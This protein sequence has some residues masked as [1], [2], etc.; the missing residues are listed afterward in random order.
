MEPLVPIGELEMFAHG[1]DHAEGI[2]V[3][4]EGVVYV[5]GEAG[6]LYRIG[7]DDTVE[8]VL[9]TGGWLLGLA[10]D[11]AGRIYACDA[12]KRCVWRIDPA[13]KS[14][15][16]FCEG[17]A[18]RPMLSPNWGC[19]DAAGNY[20]VSDS[21]EWKGA[22]GLIW[23][24][25][26]GSAPEVWTEDSRDFPNG[27]AISADGSDLLVLESTPGALVA[28]TIA[29]DGSAGARRVL[30][31]LDAVPDGVAVATD[32]S[33]VIACYRPDVIYRW[34]EDVG[35]EILALDPE[36]VAIAAPTNVAF[37]GPGLDTM[38]VPNIGRWHLTRFSHPELTGVPLH[39]PTAGQLGG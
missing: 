26:P 1:L 15:E 11:G 39:Y 3:T 21:G 37:T 6:Q 16:V 2:A 13:A 25:R 27:M 32:G 31:K 17:T 33:L 18:E 20:Y 29:A 8:E 35:L 38:M 28:F 7:A 23:I 10:A 14:M 30:A 4:G 22:N 9:T 36:G 19:F 24:V 34:R 5:G 12:V